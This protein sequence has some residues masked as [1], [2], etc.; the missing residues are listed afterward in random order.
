M[1]IWKWINLLLF[2]CPVMSDSATPRAAAR[3]S[4][5]S[6][7]PEVHVYLPKFISIASVMPSSHLILCTLFS[8]C[9]Q[10]FPASG[11]F[12]ISRQFSSDDQNTGASASAS[13]FPGNVQGWSPL[14]SIGLIS[15]LSKGLAGVF[16][17]TTVQRH[18]CF[19]VL[20]SLRSSSHNRTWQLG[21]P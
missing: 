16:S 11:T 14:R 12:P 1:N 15:L 6:P 17:S 19:G 10:S 21:R 9:P 5:P 4:R 7:S 13:V 8:F 20:P 2:S 3:P 18:Q